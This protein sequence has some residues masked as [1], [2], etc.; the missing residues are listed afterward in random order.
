M[1]WPAARCR[2]RHWKNLRVTS[3]AEARMRTAGGREFS[4]RAE[5]CC[6]RACPAAPTSTRTVTST[7]RPICAAF[8]CNGADLTGFTSILNSVATA[9]GAH[10]QADGFLPLARPRFIPAARRSCVLSLA[11]QQEKSRLEW[12][13]YSRDLAISG[14]GAQGG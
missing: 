14:T 11:Q 12:A 9:E 2:S 10:R 7:D 13:I 5:R 3:S 4:M 1:G 8:P 6:S